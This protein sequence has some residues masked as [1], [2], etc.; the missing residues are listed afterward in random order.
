M[1]INCIWCGNELAKETETK[2]HAFPRGLG[3]TLDENLW[4]PSCKDC[5]TKI[6]HAE[7]EVLTRSEFAIHRLAKNLKPRKPNVL[8]SGLIEPKI[9]LVKN[10]QIKKYIVVSFR[11]GETHPKTLPALEIDPK[12][13]EGFIHAEKA[14]DANRLLRSIKDELS[15]KP[16]ENKLVF[17]MGTHLLQRLDQEVP[18]DPDFHPRVYLSRRDRLYVCARDPEEALA[19]MRNIVAL[20]AAGTLRERDQ[21]NWQTFEIPAK[22]SHKIVFVYKQEA[23]KRVLL[24]IAYA[25]TAAHLVREGQKPLDLPHI[26]QAVIGTNAP[27]PDIRQALEAN[28]E[29]LVAWTDCLVCVVAPIDERLLGI[30]GIYSSWFLVDLG[31]IKGAP[32]LSEPFGAKCKAVSKKKQRW[33]SKQEAKELLAI[34]RRDIF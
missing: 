12:S 7:T 9:S 10:P 18:A 32:Q 30:V 13:G 4:V 16:R 23:L 25:I 28:T 27:G 34:C 11:L 33:L 20:E 22:T 21:G 6:S 5:Q 29:K 24:K 1:I 15:K 26:T 8:A 3:G 17:E 2:D 14:D 19:L 31:S